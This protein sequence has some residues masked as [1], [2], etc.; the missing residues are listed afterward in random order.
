V[1][2]TGMWRI[3][4]MDLW[5]RDAID[6]VGPGFMAFGEDGRGFW[7]RPQRLIAGHCQW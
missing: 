3:V 7:H 6:L 4:E 5:D 1:S 2:P